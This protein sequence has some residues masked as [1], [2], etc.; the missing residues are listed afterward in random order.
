NY[1]NFYRPVIYANDVILGLE[2]NE[3]VTEELRN[4]LIGEAKFLRGLS[5]FYLWNLYGG[6]VILDKPTPVTETYLP[7]NSEEEVI[8]FIINDFMDAQQRLPVS[9]PTSEVGR[10]TK[11]AAIM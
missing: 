2:D 6:V 8:Q 5:Y 9:Y 7:R 10:A 4:R 1:R 3:N 11:G